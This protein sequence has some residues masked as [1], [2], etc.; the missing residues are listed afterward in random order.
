MN[1]SAAPARPATGLARDRITW[2]LYSMLAVYSLALNALG[3]MLPYLRQEFG[4]SNTSSS[5]PGS[6]FAAGM[7]LAGLGGARLVRRLGPQLALSIG[8]AGLAGGGLLLTLADRLWLTLGACLLMGS[9][10][11]LV[12]LLVPTLLVERHAQAQARSLTEANVGGSM[13]AV[14]APVLIGVL[15]QAGAGWRWLWLLVALS[16]LGLASVS[17]LQPAGAAPPPAERGAPSAGLA[18]WL[19]WSALL[20]AVVLEFGTLFWAADLLRARLQL[21]QAQATITAS[22]FVSMMLA[23]RIGGGFLLRWI[24]AR[25]VAVGAYIITGCGLILYVLAPQGA[26]TLAGLGLLGVGVA[27]LYPLSLSQLMRSAPGAA[28]QAGARA[29][30]ASGLA[31]LGGPLLLGWL[32]DRVTIVAAHGVLAMALLGVVLAHGA[33]YL[34][35]SSADRHAALP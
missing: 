21:P 33:G 7:I 25:W 34:L 11:S 22:F 15:V 31:I 12:L 35:R 6:S 28:A 10:G 3:P 4:L 9:L 14:A 23:G 16:G 29:C 24:A 26:L 2:V 5:L 8:C 20:C 17:A 1:V 13:A 18:F 32:S 27:N 30:L 19:A